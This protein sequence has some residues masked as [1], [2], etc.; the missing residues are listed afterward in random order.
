M[1][2]FDGLMI[3]FLHLIVFSRL[4][5][6][7][8]SAGSTSDAKVEEPAKFYSKENSKSEGRGAK[9]T[10][11][12]D[13]S[14]KKPPKSEPSGERENIARVSLSELDTIVKRLEDLEQLQRTKVVASSELALAS[15][16]PETD[17]M[18]DVMSE[19][20]KQFVVTRITPKTD[21]EC[22]FNYKR[23][24]CEP[25]CDCEF[26]FKFGD[27]S[28]SRMC[29]RIPD[30]QK[31]PTCSNFRNDPSDEPVFRRIKR[32]IGSM[33]GGL[34]RNYTEILAVPTDD[35]CVFDLQRL[36]CFP[37]DVCSFRYKLWDLSLS[38]SC[39]RKD[40]N[41]QGGS[42]EDDYYSRDVY[43]DFEEDEFEADY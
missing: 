10:I 25:K 4:A 19:Q 41:V 21:R 5:S 32:K 9:K 31:D 14:N 2:A 43:D 38:Q 20:F 23:W 22:I 33:F 39:R 40:G 36:K 17:T 27:Y 13:G 18:M 6:S 26:H 12:E 29:R 35:D 28:P 3:L 15:K 42:K 34:L 11:Y 16:V 7:N 37:D 8:E 1:K 30:F 24:R